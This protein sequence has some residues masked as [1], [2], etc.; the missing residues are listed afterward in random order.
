M[1]FICALSDLINILHC[2]HLKLYFRMILTS[3]QV[4]ESY[5][6]E[7]IISKKEELEEE[8]LEKDEL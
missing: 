3:S 2:S 4:M 1:C 6:E 5:Q 7:N 8:R